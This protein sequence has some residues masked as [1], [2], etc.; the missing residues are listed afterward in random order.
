M[1]DD[2]NQHRSPAFQQLQMRWTDQH[3]YPH[4]HHG[5]PAQEYTEYGWGTPQIPNESG[6]FVHRPGLQSLQPLVMPP[7]PSMLNNGPSRTNYYPSVV[8]PTQ[9]SST[10]SP[11]PSMTPVS[12]SSTRSGSTPRRTLTDDERRQMCQYHEANPGKKQTEIGSK[13][14]TCN[15]S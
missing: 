10:V 5:T 3:Q 4:S 14:I 8:P 15:D 12:A 11:T 6:T 9:V 13:S 7:W 2:P 1:E